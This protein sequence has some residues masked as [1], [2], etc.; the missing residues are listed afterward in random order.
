MEQRN[1]KRMTNRIRSTHLMPIIKMTLTLA[2]QRRAG[3]MSKQVVFEYEIMIMI[4]LRG[5]QFIVIGG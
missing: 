4:D 3:M 2:L 1:A 5:T